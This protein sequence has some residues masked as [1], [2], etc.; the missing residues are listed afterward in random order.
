ML[1]D[2]DDGDRNDPLGRIFFFVPLIF[3]SC[4]GGT[5]GFDF[6]RTP[7][8]G[9]DDVDEDES[10]WFMA[11]DAGNDVIAGMSFSEFV[12]V[13]VASTKGTHVDG[14]DSV[15]ITENK[16]DF[17]SCYGLIIIITLEEEL[18]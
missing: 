17:H 16:I 8:C 2:D 15:F 12:M 6:L 13:S 4:S 9:A 5:T 3:I 10:M 7:E 18:F 14:T 1:T 11:G